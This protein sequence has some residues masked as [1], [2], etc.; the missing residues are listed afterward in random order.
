MIR[1]IGNENMSSKGGKVLVDEKKFFSAVRK[2][3]KRGVCFCFCFFVIRL[4][5]L[6]SEYFP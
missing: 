5:Y 4:T 3:L 6:W 2:C 1:R